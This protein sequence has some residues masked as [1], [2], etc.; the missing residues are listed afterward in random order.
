MNFSNSSH[1]EFQ[2]DVIFTAVILVLLAA[3]AIALEHHS[4]KKKTAIRMTPT[5]PTQVVT[6]GHHMTPYDKLVYDLKFQKR[7]DEDLS[8]LTSQG[9]AQP[10]ID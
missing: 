1:T 10:A 8:K 6:L 7:A 4:L 5:A 2:V 9:N 3:L